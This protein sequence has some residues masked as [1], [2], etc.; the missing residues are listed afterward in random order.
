MPTTKKKGEGG[1]STLAKRLADHFQKKLL[2][3]INFN[4]ELTEHLYLCFRPDI[5]KPTSDTASK[6]SDILVQPRSNKRRKFYSIIPKRWNL[7][8]KIDK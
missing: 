2:R 5:S 3:F 4:Y 1:T 6:S 8:D 7:D